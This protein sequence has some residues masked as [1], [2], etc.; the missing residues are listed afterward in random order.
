MALPKKGFRKITVEGHE[1]IWKIRKK[2]S[3][4][5]IHDVPLAI[6]IQNENGGQL[7]LLTIG[8]S[9]SYFT[10]NN[11]FKITPA[12]IQLCIKKAINTG[13]NHGFEGPQLELDCSEIIKEFILKNND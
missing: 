12:L 1:F 4:N 8:Y 11:Q 2:I 10:E 5:E 9:R 13:W 3:W 6:P 7:L